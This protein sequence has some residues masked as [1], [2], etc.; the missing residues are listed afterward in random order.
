MSSD[1]AKGVKP[2]GNASHGLDGVGW[3]SS[4]DWKYVSGLEA[5]SGGGAASISKR[6]R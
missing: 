3:C 5:A 2:R 6:S 4:V 1:V